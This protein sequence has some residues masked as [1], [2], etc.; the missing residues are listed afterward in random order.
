VAL[1]LLKKSYAT[2]IKRDAVSQ[3]FNTTA[4]MQMDSLDS[5]AVQPDVFRGAGAF[6]VWTGGDF[7]S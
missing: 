6:V 4:R 5:K 2:E 7:V 1:A 3:A